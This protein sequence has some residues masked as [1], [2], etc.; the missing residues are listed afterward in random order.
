MPFSRML[1]SVILEDGR[2]KCPHCNIVQPP[3]KMNFIR[4]LA[5]EHEEVTG[6]LASEFMEKMTKEKEATTEE[7]GEL[8]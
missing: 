4:H 7:V 2:R 6:D 8:D 5:M 1:D 3:S